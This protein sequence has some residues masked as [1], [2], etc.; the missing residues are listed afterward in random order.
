LKAK[1][2]QV[3]VKI[4]QR[5]G[6]KVPIK[7]LI[8]KILWVLQATG[9]KATQA[10]LP[11]RLVVG[12]AM[13]FHSLGVLTDLAVRNVGKATIE[14]LA[15]VEA[16][17]GEGDSFSFLAFVAEELKVDLIGF[18]SFQGFPEPS[19]PKDQRAWG[20]ETKAGQIKVSK[21]TILK[22][23]KASGLPPA[24]IP[25]K[26]KLVPGFFEQSLD[27]F[28]P[29]KKFFFVN[30]DVDLYSSYKTCLPY[31]WKHTAQGGVICF[32]EYHNPK[33]PGAKEAIDEF[34]SLQNIH[35]EIETISGRG[36]ILKV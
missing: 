6:L 17:L 8:A 1:I 16:G 3:V 4:L 29:N 28:S 7:L 12:N 31:F 2:R 34:C 24:F 35:V 22:K 9:L 30:L 33:W 19:S 23:L 10:E 27:E 13:R 18:D 25:E 14:R 20:P 32:D 21:D 5:T 11:A 15:M 36:Y 26:I